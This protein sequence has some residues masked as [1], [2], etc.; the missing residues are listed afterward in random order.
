MQ[1]AMNSKV[2]ANW[3][4]LEHEWYRAIWIECGEMLD[5]Y[6]WK[7]WKAQECDLAQVELELIDIFHFGLS[8]LIQRSDDVDQLASELAEN[9]PAMNSGNKFEDQLEAFA[10]DCLV[11]KT[12]NLALFVQLAHSINMSSDDLYVG[13]I[14]KNVLNRFRQDFGYKSGEYIKIWNG[15]E[16]NEVLVE[17]CATLNVGSEAFQEELYEGLKAAYPV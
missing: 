5:H 7:W 14:G 13:Y 11:T 9:W 12:F 4:D 10:A 8:D 2:N 15:K 1:D 16:D 6:G 17:L 3:I